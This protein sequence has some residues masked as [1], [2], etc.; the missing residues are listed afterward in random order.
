MVSLNKIQIGPDYRCQQPLNL[1]KSPT[2]DSLV[3]QSAIGRCLHVLEM[4]DTSD[5]DALRVCLCEDDY[6]GW[7]SAKDTQHL[8]AV[9][10]P[11]R[12]TQMTAADIQAQIPAVIRFTKAAMDQPNIYLWGGTIAPNYDC[13]GLMQAAFASVGVILPRDSYQQEE[14]VDPIAI[15]HLKPG[16]LLFFGTRDRTTHVA[17]YLGE[18]RYI[19]S[20]GREQGRNG[21]GIDAITDLSDPI[22]L[23]YYRQ[24]RGAGRI[25]QSYQATRQP[26]SCR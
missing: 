17:L 2:C 10:H 6:P 20:S 22:S 25:N 13:S 5:L 21:I 7:L 1:Y 11:Y 19:H 26:I 14:F 16:D 23:T 24:L 18:G 4:P 8:T 9:L 3:T 15:E 12:P